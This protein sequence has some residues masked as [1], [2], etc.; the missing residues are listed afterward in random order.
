MEHLVVDENIRLE[1]VKL[2]MANVIF[3][4]IEQNR[5]FLQEW[6]PF[7]EMTQQI[8]DTERFIQSILNQKGQKK[9]EIY[10]IW[11]KEEFAGLIG[12]KETDWINKKTELGYWLAKKMEKKGT[13]TACVK[14][15]IKYAFQKLKLNRVQIKVAV[16]NN[17]SKLIPERLGFQFEGIERSGELHQN[18]FLDLQIFSLTKDHCQF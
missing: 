1:P 4:T 9:D 7:V 18:K 15:L 2:W 8:S 12:F 17:R 14:K 5:K 11:V 13:M 10:S 6:L 3:S 16:G